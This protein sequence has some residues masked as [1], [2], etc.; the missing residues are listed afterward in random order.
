LTASKACFGYKRG[1][2]LNAFIIQSMRK[3]SHL[4]SYLY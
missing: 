4:S 3:L 1:L 2:F